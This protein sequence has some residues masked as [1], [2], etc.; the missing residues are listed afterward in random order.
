[1]VRGEEA[2]V[3]RDVRGDLGRPLLV[4][5]GFLQERP[6]LGGLAGPQDCHGPSEKSYIKN[7]PGGEYLVGEFTHA[8]GSKYV[9]V[10]NKDG[11]KSRYL[12]IEW[13]KPDAGGANP[14]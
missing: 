1:M 14:S 5:H 13:N 7:I 3:L 4:A 12:P 11:K 6:G 8:D 9:M 10:V 2:A